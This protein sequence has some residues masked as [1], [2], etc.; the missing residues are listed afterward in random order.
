KDKLVLVEGEID[1]ITLRQYGIPTAATLGA[2]KTKGFGLLGA[3]RQVLL[4]YDMDAAGDT[5]AEKAA[6]ELGRYRC[7]RVT[8]SYKDPNDMLQ[9][10]ATKE[11][12]LHCLRE[13]K[14]L[15]TDLKSKNVAD[16]MLE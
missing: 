11:G 4:G 6:G 2:G 5:G 15:A 10:G 3:I 1:A 12:L 9:T 16:S 8:W 14:A 13:A 7:K